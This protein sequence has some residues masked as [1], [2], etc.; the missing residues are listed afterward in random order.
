MPVLRIPATI[1]ITV[2]T[3]LLVSATG[4]AAEKPLTRI[5]FG[6]C[7]KQDKPQPIWDSILAGKPEVFL[8]IGDNIYA[9]TEDMDVMRKKYKMLTDKPGYQRLKKSCRILATW[10]DHDYG[11]NDAGV[12]YAKKKESQQIFLDVFGVAKDSPRRTR[13]GVYH[14][15]IVG[16]VGKRVQ[17]IL[18]DTRYFRSPLL[19]KRRFKA[20]P[21]EGISGPYR[22]D[23]NP[24]STVLG[25]TQWKWLE[26]QL[27]KP[28]EL[29]ILASSIQLIANKHHWE[30]WGHF[31]KERQRVFDL[32]GKTKANGVVIISGDRHKA[33]ISRLRKS[34]A[35]YPLFDVTSSSLN[36]PS[37][38]FT[39]TGVRWGNELNPH[40]IGL[41]YFETNFGTIHIDW[42]QTDPVV[43]LQVRDA[44]G[45]V[46]LQQRIRLSQLRS[47]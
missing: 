8:F 43:R 47:K 24:K 32:I 23:A 31:P 25:S 9:D 14:A 13:E 26:E 11:K 42:S 22:P 45:N 46:V 28:A 34:S 18:L 40:R 5:A 19:K 6:S 2:I 36:E 3:S 35:G 16:P 41:L 29:R 27:R 15:E 1:L 39:K 44:K 33:E 37:G 38:N 12:E 10:D 21:G 30:K 20:E 7:A 17:I 4:Q